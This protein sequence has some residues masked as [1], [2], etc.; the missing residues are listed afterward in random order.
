VQTG[1]IRQYVMFI[2]VGAIALFLLIS[3]FLNPSLAG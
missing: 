1:R 2:I 3:F